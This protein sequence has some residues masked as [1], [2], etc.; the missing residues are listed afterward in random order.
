M[1]KDTQ[2][3]VCCQNGW[4]EFSFRFFTHFPMFWV[5]R[6]FQHIYLIL[7]RVYPFRESCLWNF[8]SFWMC[9]ILLFKNR[10]LFLTYLKTSTRSRWIGL[11]IYPQMH[12][13]LLFCGHWITLLMTFSFIKGLRRDQIRWFSKQLP[14]LRWL[15][16]ICFK[17]L[18]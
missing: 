15:F 1:D 17:N 6:V 13:V 11:T 4:C 16:R 14:D 5:D 3:I 8:F 7:D 10:S 18:N 12:W 9:L 2:G